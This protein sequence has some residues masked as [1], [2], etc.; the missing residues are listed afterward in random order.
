M[1]NRRDFVKTT[2]LASLAT[3]TSG[4]LFA[5]EREDVTAHPDKGPLIRSFT[6]FPASGSF[7]RFIGPNSYDNAPKGI[8]GHPRKTLIVELS[9]GTRGVGTIGYRPLT[10]QVL[11][12][13]KNL[14][15]KD[16]FSLYGWKGDQI[17]SVHPDIEPYFYDS[18][19][20]WTESAI[21]DAIGHLKQKPVWKLFGRSVKEG[22]DPYD[23]TL[24]FADM[25]G[26]SDVQIIAQIGKRIKRDGYRAVK[27]KV[28]RPDKWLPGEAGVERDIEA[29]IALREA[30]GTNFNIMTDANNGY[31]NKL[32]WAIRFL[33]ACAPYN[34]YFMEELIPDD[35]AQYLKI[36]EAL[37]K[38][39]LYIP[40]ADGESIWNTDMFEVFTSYCEAGVYSFIQPDMPTCGFTNILRVARM[41][42]SYPHVKLIPHVWQSHM[43]LLMSAHIAKIQPNIPFVEDS[44]YLEHVMMSPGYEFDQGQWFVP[45]EPGWGVQLTPGY[46]QFIEEEPIV[47]Q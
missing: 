23:G 17:K 15:G 5:K 6:I 13:A 16:I 38:E 30:V 39:N 37:L 12:K 10:E 21:L 26:N 1:L 45:D 44:R 22:I 42:E 47:I 9:D 19:Y 20:S 43:G 24:Y 28:G 27:L 8:H 4:S 29:F 18:D 11:A 7:Y 3:A 14:I 31:K 35:T 2:G 46:E 41:A 32:D 34:M 40:I 25:V 33:K 36:R